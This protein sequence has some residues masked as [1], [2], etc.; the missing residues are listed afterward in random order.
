MDSNTKRYVQRVNQHGAELVE[1]PIH[2]SH[3]ALVHFREGPVWKDIQNVID[4][5]IAQKYIELETVP[6]DELKGVQEAIRQLRFVQSIP[7]MLI[8]QKES[9]ELNKEDDDESS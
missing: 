6:P 1:E 5:Q 4:L 2:S 3:D 7:D 8:E 9:H